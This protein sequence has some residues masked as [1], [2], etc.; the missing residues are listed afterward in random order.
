M[1]V[2]IV[3]GEPVAGDSRIAARES[4]RRALIV[5]PVVLIALV[6]ML[7]L[8]IPGPLRVAL[9]SAARSLGDSIP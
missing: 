3:Y 6:L 7:G 4:D 9:A 8:Y 5:G 2:T 1:V